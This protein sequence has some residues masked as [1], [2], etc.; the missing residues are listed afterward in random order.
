MLRLTAICLSLFLCVPVVSRALAHEY[1][2]EPKTYVFAPGENLAAG[3]FNGQNFNGGEMGYFEK[4]IRRFE[5]ASASGTVA[6]T[7]RLGDKPAL[8]MAAPAEGLQV[9]LFESA[10]DTVAYRDFE[11]FR[12]FVTHKNFPGA[13]DR[14]VARGLALEGFTEFYTRHS[15]ALLAVGDGKG[16]DRAYGLVTEIVAL[17]NPYTDDLGTG[18]PVQVF[19]QNA[20]RVD[21]QIELFEKNAQGD[22]AITLHRT[23]AQGMAVLPVKRGHSYLVDAV[24]LREPEAGSTALAQGA[25]WESLW[26]AL[27]FGVPE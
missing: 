5:V 12:K 19:Y 27:T 26:A 21:A 11:Q 7:A 6:V 15:K 24:V 20:P 14:H 25:L 3:L 23:D 13:L 16:Q 17:K 22:V 9:V 2:I 1:W 8:T 18:L 10:G 4:T